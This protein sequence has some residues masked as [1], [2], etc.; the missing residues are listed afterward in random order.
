MQF[1]LEFHVRLLILGQN[2]ST[3]QRNH[4]ETA[5]ILFFEIV[6]QF[7]AESVL[8]FSVHFFLKV[9]DRCIDRS[10]V[11]SH[12]VCSTSRTRFDHFTF[13]HI[14]CLQTWRENNVYQ[15]NK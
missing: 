2:L 12:C 7:G 8:D 13:C 15:G 5:S 11:R 1:I 9:N 6:S 4:Q 3:V 10:K 14:A